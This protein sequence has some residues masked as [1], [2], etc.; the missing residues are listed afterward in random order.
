MPKSKS[1]KSPPPSKLSFRRLRRD[2]CRVS[3][4][5]HT[6]R[7]L[8]YEP[9]VSSK[10]KRAPARLNTK[11]KAPSGRSVG[12]LAD[13]LKMPLDVFYEIVS[14]LHPLDILQLA[15]ASLGIRATL[16]SKNSVRVWITARR[17]IGMPECPPDLSEPQY[18]SLVFEHIC[19]VSNHAPCIEDLLPM[20]FRHVVVVVR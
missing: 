1:K 4:D 19:F 14:Y 7:L 18:A 11:G 16:M 9:V 5:V 13:L 17:M 6:D 2:T 10:I 8:T 12:K 3:N 15:R 20:G